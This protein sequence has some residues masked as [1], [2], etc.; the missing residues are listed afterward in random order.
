MII[1]KIELTCFSCRNNIINPYFCEQCKNPFCNNCKENIT[2]TL[3]KCPFCHKNPFNP[4]KNINLNNLFNYIGYFCQYCNKV[5]N[6]FDEYNNHNKGNNYKCELCKKSFLGK[7]C[8]IGHLEDEKNHKNYILSKL[9]YKID[10]S[11]ILNSDS[12]KNELEEIK[13]ELFNDNN[14]YLIHS[15]NIKIFYDLKK[16]TPTINNSTITFPIINEKKKDEQGRLNKIDKDKLDSI[17]Q[18][19]ITPKIGNDEDKN[20]NCKYENKL[21]QIKELSKEEKDV[22]ILDA[23]EFGSSINYNYDLFYCY[24]D[25]NLN[26]NCCPKKICEPGKC[27]C[28]I[29]MEYNKKYHNLPNHYLINKNGKVSKYTFG[30]FYCKSQYNSI[31]YNNGNI[32]KSIDT[33]FYPSNPCKAC[34]EL[35]LLA[36]S[37]LGNDLY[38]KLMRKKGN[39]IK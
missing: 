9:G 30:N 11:E 32:F 25:S 31:N 28:A 1:S 4:K 13:K 14:N 39:F 29:C 23:L 33:C 3:N 5:I 34:Q 16:D 10:K 15:N 27:F 17:N 21:S 7:Y 12:K 20:L 38:E 22:I 18:K 8:F 26:C 35:N 19:I 37:Y 2:K 36:K 24:N 6:N